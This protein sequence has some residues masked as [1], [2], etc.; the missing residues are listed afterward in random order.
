[1]TKRYPSLARCTL[2]PGVWF[3]AAAVV[4]APAAAQTA[5]CGPIVLADTPP[6][7]LPIYEQPPIPSPGYIW[8][9]GYWA[10]DPDQ[11]DYYWVPG[12]WAV[13]PRPGLLWTPGYWAW[14]GGQYLFHDGYWGA[15]VG[16]YGGIAYGFGYT[17][18]GYDGGHWDNGVFFYNQTVNNLGGANITNVYNKTLVINNGATR[19][20]FNGGKD[21]TTV[22]P[23]SEQ[24]GVAKEARFA[25][26]PLQQQH[27]QVAS[28]DPGLFE[29]AN[30]G[31]PPV[32]ATAKPADL[33]GASITPAVES[34]VGQPASEPN[35]PAPKPEKPKPTVEEKKPAIEE[36]K[37]E[38]NASPDSTLKSEPRPQKEKPPIKATSPP[39]PHPML[40]GHPPAPQGKKKPEEKKREPQ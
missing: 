19:V 24:I 40:A 35:K 11:A 21:G 13:P 7:P 20:S 10:W 3:V 38:A 6:P 30:R 9:P 29:K 26:T 8:S 34:G 22:K 39:G 18:I 31:K 25:P 2:L 15:H 32:A 14:L 12:T 28:K 36:K 27:V 16:F 33:K 1:M 37:P 23:T 17:G 4:V 5:A